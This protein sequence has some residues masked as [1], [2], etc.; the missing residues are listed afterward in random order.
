MRSTRRS[1]RSS[2]ISRWRRS[3]ACCAGRISKM[4]RFSRR[5][6]SATFS[7]VSTSTNGPTGSSSIAR[8]IARCSS[9]PNPDPNAAL[10]CASR[11]CRERFL[12]T[13]RSCIAYNFTDSQRHPIASE[14]TAVAMTPQSQQS[15]QAARATQEDIRRDLQASLE[16]RRELGPGYDEQFLDALVEKLNRQVQQTRQT[17]VD[18]GKHSENSVA[19]AICSLIFGIPIVAI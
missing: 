19:L 16:A 8:N 5:W 15:P 12:L 1:S 2:A 4:S 14:R 11:K 10:D 6:M 9:R 3:V 13:R 17:Q 7:Q 18:N